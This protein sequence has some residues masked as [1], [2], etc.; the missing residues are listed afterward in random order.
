MP[1]PSRNVLLIDSTGRGHAIADLFQRSD[2]SVQVFYGPGN[3]SVA[4]E[5]ICT[6]PDISLSDPES[7]VRF[8]Q[9][10][11]IDFVFVS[12]IDALSTGYVDFLKT[13]GI[14]TIGPDRAAARLEASKA[15]TKS[16]LQRYNVKTAR[17]AVFDR[18]EPAK[19]YIRGLDYDVVVK[20]D[21]LCEGNGA[22]VCSDQASALQAVDSIML[23]R[24]HKDA[25]NR[26]VV[27]ERLFGV[28]ISISA[29]FDGKEFLMFPAALDYKRSDDGNK[30][31]NCDG[32]GS[33]SPH[34][35][36]DKTL[37][38][39]I[40]T[41]VLEPLRAAILGEGLKYTG[42]IYI[43]AML[44]DDGI[45]V[46]EIN[47]RLG[48]SEAEAVLPKVQ[49]NFVRLCEGVLLGTLSS[50]SLETDDK[51]YCNVVAAQGPTL[52]LDEHGREIRYPGWPH[53]DFEVGFPISGL[54]AV[55]CRNSRLFFANV[56][57]DAEDTLVT[58]G[59]RVLHVTGIGDNY[60]Q[61]VHHAYANIEK[62]RFKGMSYRSDIGLIYG[63]V[64]AM[65][66]R[67]EI[68]SLPWT[69]QMPRGALS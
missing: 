67:R 5:R 20:A 19:C 43:G 18:P 25:G 35:L 46:I 47:V 55:N 66:Q 31:V 1:N 33:L 50:M 45:K 51:C 2:P 13:N 64:D 56:R 37:Y 69:W 40:Q 22:Y 8:C 61:A 41:E 52:R 9:A 34:P 48:D 36:A 3:P 21:G 58:A 32:M 24:A 42:F 49:S 62:I 68:S 16:L 39:E 53:G 10:R 30:G 11:A 28:E 4:D 38:R 57:R 65:R 7:A 15:F 54:E 23:A 44:C 17:F 12:H 29:L 26:I 6:V 60:A 27:E 14:P 59:G 63:S